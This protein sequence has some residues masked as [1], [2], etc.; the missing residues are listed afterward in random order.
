M[1]LWY[2]GVDPG[3][4]EGGITLVS[5]ETDLIVHPMPETVTELWDVF[6]DCKA[7]NDDEPIVFAFLEKVHSMPGQGVSSTFKFGNGNGRLEMALTAAGLSWDYVAPAKW[8]REL[9]ITVIKNEKKTH[10][11]NRHKDLAGRLF[12]SYKP[13]HKTADSVLISE[14]CRRMKG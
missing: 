4:T 2:M 3:A 8:Q 14:Y 5:N 12:P 1:R 13:V 10:K 6:A 11:K 7:S 9:G